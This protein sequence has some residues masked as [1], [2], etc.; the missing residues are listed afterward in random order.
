MTGRSLSISPWFE[1]R[2]AAEAGARA[3]LEST[4]QDWTSKADSTANQT[5]EG[6]R[7]TTQLEHALVTTVRRC[8]P[9]VSTLVLKATLVS[10]HETIIS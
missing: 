8:T 6:L 1:G 7:R 9:T 10:A 5:A 2:L 3:T 4:L